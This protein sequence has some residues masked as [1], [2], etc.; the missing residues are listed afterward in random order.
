MTSIGGT[1]SEIV[2]GDWRGGFAGVGQVEFGDFSCP[3]SAPSAIGGSG[4]GASPSSLL[5]VAASGCFMLTLVGLLE[6][7]GVRAV[8]IAIDSEGIYRGAAPPE[9]HAIVH[10]P[11]VSVGRADAS[12]LGLVRECFDLAKQFCAATRAMPNI[13]V[14]VEGKTTIEFGSD[15]LVTQDDGH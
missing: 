2:R 13:E 14:T 7:R 10:R 5:V 12:R 15:G 11:T 1:H 4:K 9:L 8:G 3:V 6:Q